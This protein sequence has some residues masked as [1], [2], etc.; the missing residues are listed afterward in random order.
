[1][2]LITYS[3]LLELLK[4]GVV[5]NFDPN[6]ING[7]SLDVRLG[8]TVWVE[9]QRGG[10]IDLAAKET[11]NMQRVDITN[12][13]HCLTPGEFILGGTIELFNLPTNMGIWMGD[14]ETTNISVSSEFRLKS[15][16]ARAGLDQALAVWCDPGWH[17]S[18]LTMELRN[19]L[20]YHQ[21]KL[22][23]GMKIGQMVFWAGEP[24]PDEISYGVIGQYNHDKSAQPSRGLK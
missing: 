18:S 5:E 4:D 10:I 3:G 1:M 13:W 20:Q 23:P 6:C 11:P 8:N 2:S 19:N 17:G 24:I 9:D 21:L 15:S 14:K 7:A 22:R 12:S 16:G